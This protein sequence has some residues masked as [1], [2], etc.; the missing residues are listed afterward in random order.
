MP[1]CFRNT[2]FHEIDAINVLNALSVILRCASDSIQ[3]DASMLLQC[4]KRLLAHAAFTDYSANAKFL[5]NVALIRLLANARRRTRSLDMPAL[6][7]LQ[8]DRPAVIYNC[9]IQINWSV[10]IHQIFMESIAARMHFSLDD[11]DISYTQAANLLFRNRSMQ[12]HL[13]VRL[14]SRLG[15]R[16][17]G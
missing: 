3:I 7:I 1:H 17:N 15:C 5:N 8:H 14:R 10:M 16:G 6:L 2:E 9:A 4:L 13:T 11:D 12:N